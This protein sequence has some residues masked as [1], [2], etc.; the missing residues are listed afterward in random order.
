MRC[1]RPTLVSVEWWYSACQV[2]PHI[3]Y[4]FVDNIR[5][6]TDG[7]RDLFHRRHKCYTRCSINEYS[8]LNVLYIF[9]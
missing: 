9:A 6:G 1:R 7:T 5:N 3:I 2:P 8:N 4:C